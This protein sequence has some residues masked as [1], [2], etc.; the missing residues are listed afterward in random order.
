MLINKTNLILVLF[1]SILS[2]DTSAATVGSDL[3]INALLNQADWVVKSVM[4]IL[5]FTSVTCWAIVIFKQV[6]VTLA[7]KNSKAL[8]IALIGF[9]QLS[10]DLSVNKAIPE[11]ELLSAAKQEC[12]WTINH[13]GDDEKA[14]FRIIERLNT[15]TASLTSSRLVGTGVLA[16]VGAV[17]PFVGLFGTVWGIMNSFIGIAENETTSLTVV[18]PGIAEALL[19][20]AFGLVAAIP[21]VIFYNYFSRKVNAYKKYLDVISSN[22]LLIASRQLELHLQSDVTQLKIAPDSVMKR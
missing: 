19:A 22:I 1:L 3:S 18:A 10:D 6:E 5:L 13:A 20:T 15:I 2:M 11:Y 4:G 12:E 8:E 16:S 17:A 9:K 7:I 14:K 21:A